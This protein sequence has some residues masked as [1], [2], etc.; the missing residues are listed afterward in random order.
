MLQSIRVFVKADTADT[1]RAE[2]ALTERVARYSA[3]VEDFA[4]FADFDVDAALPKTHTAHRPNG[5]NRDRRVETGVG[6]IRLGGARLLLEEDARGRACRSGKTE[7][8]EFAPG[9][10]DS[11][12]VTPRGIV[13]DNLCTLYIVGSEYVW[14]KSLVR[15]QWAQEMMLSGTGAWQFL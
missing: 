1:A 2:P 8:D 7:L 4:L 11:T 13:N 12:H 15:G 9:M 3:D 5:A 10:T 6:D 14:V